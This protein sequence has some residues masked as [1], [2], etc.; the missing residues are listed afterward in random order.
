[1]PSKAFVAKQFLIFLVSMMSD[2]ENPLLFL[3]D[4][5]SQ[6]C[7]GNT[8]VQISDMLRNAE[9]RPTRQR[10]ALAK[11]LF[12][13]GKRH[14]SAEQLHV[15]ALDE[16]VPV[17]L[18]TIYN[19]LHQFKDASLLRAVVIDSTKTY[20]DTNTNHHHHFYMEED[21]SVVD[22]PYDN[23]QFGKLPEPPEGMEIAKVDVIVRLRRK[24]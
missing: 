8:S 20:F 2:Q 16:N 15:E 13:K 24:K 14:I 17:S 7:F 6:T 21:N 23:V 4:D 18:A 1:M 10:V 11:L 9:L 3:S 5:D 22:I 12:S 19:T